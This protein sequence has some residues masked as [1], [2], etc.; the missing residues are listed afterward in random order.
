[1]VKHVTLVGGPADR[2]TISVESKTVAVWVP[3]GPLNH[4]YQRRSCGD[5]HFAYT[6]AAEPDADEFERGFAAYTE[7]MV[8]P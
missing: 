8:A 5:F 3:E 4:E 6:L 2:L 1:M 7:G